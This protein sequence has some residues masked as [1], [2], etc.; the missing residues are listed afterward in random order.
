MNGWGT[1]N[2]L[3]Y[4]GRGVYQADLSLDAQTDGY[5]FKIASE[6]WSTVNF[7]AMSGDDTAVTL[8][9]ER[10]LAVTDH[11]LT[12]TVSTT[13][14]HRFRLDASDPTAPILV[15]TD[16]D[17]APYGYGTTQSSIYV[18]GGFN[19]WGT[20]SEAH[21]AGGDVYEAV[22]P[23]EVGTY[24]FKVASE[25]WATVNLGAGASNTVTIGTAF[26][27]LADGGGNLSISIA[28]AN[29]YLFTVDA[30]GETPTLWVV[31]FKPFG[32]TEVF[33]R[34]G[35]N[36]WGTDNLLVFKGTARYSTHIVLEV[37]D[38]EFK[39]ASED[40]ST[41]NLGAAEGAATQVTPGE[42]YTSL[43]Q[44]GGNLMI[45]IDTAGT[46]RFQV[47]GAR[48]VPPALLVEQTPGS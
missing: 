18:R 20:A 23:V 47:D 28:E 42:A 26:G 46:Y 34:G 39:V 15:V 12:I 45:T 31:P 38:Y 33:V 36:G 17:M 32:A 9:A 29:E 27:D 6:D 22:I 14:N 19:E 2:A 16:L 5:L 10:T 43:A 3:T 41:V 37:G 35:M 25:D 1:D 11:N 40:W 8:D 44:G 24:E 4:I 48:N 21:Y 7:G 13:A 30:S